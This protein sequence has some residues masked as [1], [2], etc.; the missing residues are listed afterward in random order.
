MEG[1]KSL[2]ISLVI[3]LS[4][5]YQKRITDIR[6]HSHPQT[7]HMTLPGNNTLKATIMSFWVKPKQLWTLFLAFNKSKGW[8][9][10]HSLQKDWQPRS[11]CHLRPK[12]SSEHNK[13]ALEWLTEIVWTHWMHLRH[14]T[15]I[16]KQMFPPEQKFFVNLLVM[17]FK[18]NNSLTIKNVQSPLHKKLGMMSF[19]HHCKWNSAWT[20]VWATHLHYCESTKSFL[21]CNT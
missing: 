20:W 3:P 21:F 11:V 13:R 7:L 15:V 16:S 12:Q 9:Y 6:P 2:I 19:G 8:G 17:Y 14:L 5:K 18:P 4:P 10:V 1:W